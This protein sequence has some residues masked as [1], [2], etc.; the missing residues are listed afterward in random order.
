MNHP[1]SVKQFVLNA[2]LLEDLVP[3]ADYINQ[4]FWSVAVEWKIYF[5]F[6]VIVWIW[7]RYRSWVT[8][9]A[10]AVVGYGLMVIWVWHHYHIL[11]FVLP[12]Q[13]L[14]HSCPWY[15]FL[16]GMGCCAAQS[17]VRWENARPA[18]WAAGAGA[19]VVVSALLLWLFPITSRGS[20]VSFDPH[21]PIIDAAVGAAVACLLVVL[22]QQAEDDKSSPLL[23]ALSWRPLVQTGVFAYSIYLIHFPVVSVFSQLL[24]KG[25]LAKVAT[26]PAALLGL[27]VTLVA[28]VVGLAY[29]FFLAFERPFLTARRK[30]AIPLEA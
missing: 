16:F 4:P 5:L 15:V 26:H 6:P 29:L 12:H 24:H 30:R 10:T 8:L 27:D 17:S 13:T 1:M 3:D 11:S 25:R 23:H 20:G 22:K 21:L 28:F 14:T 9:A 2:L 18:P 7:Q 19:F